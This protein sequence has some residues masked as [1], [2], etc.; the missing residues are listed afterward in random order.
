VAGTKIEEIIQGSDPDGDPLN[1]VIWR[2]ELQSRFP[3]P[4]IVLKTHSSLLQESSISLGQ[5]SC[6]HVRASGK[7]E[8]VF[9]SRDPAKAL[10]Q[11]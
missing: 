10:V 7:Y 5:N 8:V 9:E 2:T 6:N 3:K 1:E 4:L 11:L